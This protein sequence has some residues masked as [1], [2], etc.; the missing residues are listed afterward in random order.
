MYLCEAVLVITF[1]VIVV[2]EP[3]AEDKW[4]YLLILPVI[5]IFLAI[6]TPPETMSEPSVWVVDW[7]VF[8]TL[9]MA[10]NFI[11]FPEAIVKSVLLPEIYSVELP[12]WISFPE[13]NN[14]PSLWTWVNSTSESVPK[15]NLELSLFILIFSVDSQVPLFVVAQVNFLSCVPFNNKPPP[16]AVVLSGVV[17]LPNIINLSSTWIW[18]ALI[19]LILPVTFKFPNT[20]KLAPIVVLL[21]VVIV[22]VVIVPLEGL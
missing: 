9:V 20:F 18:S 15:D 6:P 1:T 5:Y 16:V 22:L 4:V 14:K 17:T 7:V 19:A 11:L 21:V 8:W 10:S 13:V 3:C 2:V 12:Y